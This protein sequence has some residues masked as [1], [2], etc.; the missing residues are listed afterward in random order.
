M[1]VIGGY[2]KCCGPG[3][4]TD[5]VKAYDATTN[6]WTARARYPVRVRSTNGAAVV[7]GKIYVTGGFTRRW[8]EPDGPWRLETL[9]SLYVYTPSSNTWVRKRDIPVYSVNGATVGYQGM[10][11]VAA[12]NIVWRY[13]PGTNQ[14][15]QFA[16]RPGRD[17]WN[18][19]AGVIGGKLYLAEE[20]GGALDILDLSTGTWTAGPSRP[21]RACHMASTDWRAKLYMFGFC[22]D[23][24]TDP[25]TRDRGL[26]FDPATSTWSE[27]APAP[28]R[29][30]AASALA[31]VFV[32]E[33]PRLSMVYGVRPNNHYQFIP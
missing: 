12:G 17:W 11:Y 24:P 8:Q 1:Y 3:Q 23:Y 19:G 7:N 2:H 26:V 13:N 4:I 16:D 28:I 30:G 22:D 5:A 6:T 31:R 32:N 15:V 33:Q 14:W 9:K 27:V 29:G 21:Y 20:Y 10:L 18:V 25:E